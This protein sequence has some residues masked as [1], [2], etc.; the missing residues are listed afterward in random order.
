MELYVC[1]IYINT[2]FLIVCEPEKDLAYAK[3]V[4]LIKIELIMF[5]LLSALCIEL[6]NNTTRYH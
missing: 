3:H 5:G 6:L 2:L 1:T 4:L